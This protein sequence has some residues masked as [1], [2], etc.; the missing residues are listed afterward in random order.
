MIEEIIGVIIIL[1]AIRVLIT[2]NRAE[3]ML[4]VNVIDFALSAL[5]AIYINTP[6]GLIVA[7]T[8]FVTST[9]S[10]NAIAYSLNR[11]KNEVILS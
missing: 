6:F 10:S 3:K 11:L 4:Y 2:N 5:I 9:I 7:I 8:F 1:M